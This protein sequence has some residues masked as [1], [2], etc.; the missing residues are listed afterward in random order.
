MLEVFTVGGGEYLVNTFNAVAA[1][2]GSGGFR[3]LI[4]V[5]MVMGLIFALVV[6]AFNLDWRAWFRWF[7]QAALLYSCL[8]V[9]TVDVKVTDRINPSLAPATVDNVPLG[10]GVMA[11]FTSQVSDFFTRHAETVFV[12]P[13]ALQFSSGGIVYGAR[14]WDKVRSFEIKDP[15]FRANLDAHLKQCVFY[16]VLY[17]NLSMR[18]LSESPDMWAEIGA[19]PAVNRAQ[20]FMRDVGGTVDIEYLTCRDAY[21]ELT[22][23]W[24][25][26]LTANVPKFAR[27]FYPKLT[28]AA[29]GARLAN[30]IP[31]VSQLFHGTPR[32]AYD[33]LRQK[34]L[35]EA[36]AAAQL[37]FGNDEADGFAL[38]RADTQARNSMTSVA[39]QAMVWVPVLNI[40]LTLVFYAMFPVIFPLFLFPRTGVPT[41][42]GYLAG[43]FYLAAW[44]P[45]YVLLH[46][47]VMDRIASE[48]AAA[49]PG[50]LSLASWGGIQS[51]NLDTATLAGFLMMSVPVLAAMLARGAMAAS[52]SAASFL[53]PAQGGGEAAALERTTGNYAY[54]DVSFANF[55]GNNRQANQWTEAGNYFAGAVRSMFRGQDGVSYSEFGNGRT[56]ID[57]S[58]GMSQLPF[59]PMMT[60]GY[61]SDLRMQGQ[62]YLN[63][64]DRIEN[65]TSTSWS[66]IQSSF[67]SATATQSSSVGNRSE[68]GKQSAFSKDKREYSGTE[69]AVGVSERTST[70]D[71]LRITEGNSVSTSFVATDSTGVKGS[72]DAGAKL[73]TPLG[74]VAG[75]GA[76]ISGS[77]SVYG[78]RDNSDIASRSSN[79][80][81]EKFTT[82]AT[83]R[84]ED[85]T[86][87]YSEGMTDSAT[88]SSGTFTR[89]ASYSDDNRT[90]SNSSGIEVRTSEAEERR[91][92]ASRYR[93][94]GNRLVAEASYAQSNGFQMSSDLSNLV[95]SRYEDMRR[96]NPE[97]HLPDL[98]N[99]NLSLTEM[100]RRDQGV[101]A[102]MSDLMSDLKARK[103]AEL[104]DVEGIGGIGPLGT[105]STLG[106]PNSPAFPG[107]DKATSE[108][109]ETLPSAPQGSVDGR[110][111]AREFGI[112]LKSGADIRS[113]D[114]GLVPAMA[115]VAAEAK[116]LGLPR[117]VITSGNDSRVHVAGSAHYDDRGLDF[118][119]RNVTVA[120]GRQWADNVS[121]RLGQGYGVQFEVFP[122][123]PERNHLHVSKRKS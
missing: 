72:L 48:M 26:H 53:Q 41:L 101:T 65:G 92:A 21:T 2:T 71:G 27:T 107:A 115:V 95:Q 88:S 4:R 105:S 66:S 102:V 83:D 30:D 112:G 43:F 82:R 78:G 61:A 109:N 104:G 85:N 93:E 123:Q 34:S 74:D 1:W 111:Y 98:A 42:K 6:T 50:G 106:F 118:R 75:S 28:E 119:G 23:G 24:N 77:A 63:E 25:A 9:P 13:S 5:V 96:E 55:N 16:D 68:S 17:G 51:V 110:P 59:K 113:I 108:T 32:S 11:S 70:N 116:E 8:M 87:R 31:V 20:K 49:A 94:I 18:T 86:G 99:P 114:G 56:V 35:V 81:L 90:Q 14:L 44:G 89:D 117:P 19:N 121:D 122:D 84:S 103:I 73:G 76:S 39:Q 29:A 38:D 79:R 47:F 36:F 37:D 91:S 54:G 97:L 58:G 64:A 52:N 12:M 10:L 22:Q 33:T 80:G 62:N 46:M 120:Q 7:L 57:S 40:V 60:A 100:Q 45:L 69:G 67:R 15:V 3:S